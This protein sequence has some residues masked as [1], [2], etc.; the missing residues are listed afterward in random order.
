MAFR[1]A[2]LTLISNQPVIIAG[3]PGTSVQK[4]DHPL[5][6]LLSASSGVL[7]LSAPAYV[8]LFVIHLRHSL[9]SLGA[10]RVPPDLGYSVG[11]SPTLQFLQILCLAYLF[12][13]YGLTLWNWRRLNLKPRNLAWSA[14]AVTVMA[15]SLLPADSSDVLEYIGFGRLAAVY[16]V[17]PYLHTYSEFT[18]HFSPYVTWDEPMP[19]GPVLL[20]I[21]AIAGVVS[22][23]QVLVAMYVIKFVWLLIHLLNAWLIYRMAKS[24]ALDPEYAL[25]VFAFNPLVLLEQ[26][27]NGHNDGLLILCGLLALFALQRGRDGLAVWLALLCALVKISGLFWLAGIVAFL[28]RQRRGR[29]LVQGVGASL[30]GVA[31]LFT[32]F[33]GPTALL[34]LMNPQWQF[35]EDS[36]HTVLIDWGGALC[37]T[38]NST[39]GYDEVFK[40]DRLIFSALFLGVCGWRLISIRDFVS[41][42]RELGHVLLILLLGYAV[43][44]YPWYI[45]WLLPIAALT[46]SERLRRT[47]AVSS[48]AVL[49]LYAF[50]YALVEQAPG[51]SAWSGLRLGMAFGVPIGF[52]VLD[53]IRE[54]RSPR[55]GPVSAKMSTASA[56]GATSR[57]S[58]HQSRCRGFALWGAECYVA[59]L[60]RDAACHVTAPSSE[61]DGRDVDSVR[62]SRRQARWTFSARGPF[63]P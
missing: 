31:F 19:Y 23:H 28:I 29:G 1:K 52:W 15:C 14:V 4:G 2:L 49:A 58:T 30:A 38:L 61:A 8:S 62:R 7:V 42:I 59:R 37:R 63:G 60:R 9:P 47:I 13:V 20:P 34:N 35:S 51:H 10:G 50:P 55:V 57:S 48:S 41:L 46:D 27:G 43:S 12:M 17:S 39:W 33:P 5:L 36:L 18:D 25:F 21:F 32:L 11:A 40:I 56:I 53:G 26:P 16:H 45:V 24:L 44:V 3:A 22:E 54:S 6:R